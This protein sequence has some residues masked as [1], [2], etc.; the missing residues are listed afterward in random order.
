[1]A[2]VS[3]FFQ[4]CVLFDT[5]DVNA[6]V[7]DKYSTKEKEEYRTQWERAGGKTRITIP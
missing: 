6:D 2:I 3:T 5:R 7:T 4:S 1:M